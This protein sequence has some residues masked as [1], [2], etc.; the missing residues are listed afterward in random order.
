MISFDVTSLFTKIPI[1]SALKAIE[2]RLRHNTDHLSSVSKLSVSDVVELVQF[3]LK[4]TFFQFHEIL[5]E[6]R[7]GTPMG[8]PMSPVVANLYMEEIEETVLKR[9]P[10][11][12]RPRLWKRYV[13]DIF[14][15]IKKSKTDTILHYLNSFN[16][17]IQFTVEHE[18]SRKLQFLDCLVKR[19]DMGV[20]STS[21]YRKPTHTNKYLHYRSAHTQ[22]VKTGIIKCLEKRTKTIC[23]TESER[24]AELN[25]LRE[26]FVANGYPDNLVRRQLK[27]DAKKRDR[28]NKDQ[29][30]PVLRLPYIPTI[31]NRIRRLCQK[32]DIRFVCSSSNTIR[33]ISCHPKDP[34]KPMDQIN[35][36]YKIPCKDCSKSYVGED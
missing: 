31:A 27:Q 4:T 34:I 22:S 14:V 15:I 35:V 18:S 20:I 3:C 29:A 11:E 25:I 5:Y 13:D 32:L 7:E 24:T 6:Q 21:V 36:I 17:C 23:L 10:R 28:D 8:S 26:V 9:M 19:G 1:D 2:K 30:L 33:S 12:V 16:K